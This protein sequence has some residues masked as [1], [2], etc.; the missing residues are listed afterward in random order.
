M[1]DFKWYNINATTLIQNVIQR[2]SEEINASKQSIIRLICDNRL[3]IKQLNRHRNT[4]LK[5]ND[6]YKQM[7]IYFYKYYHRSQHW[8]KVIILLY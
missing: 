1:W 2:Y 3:L 5:I 6:Q 4:K 8:K 7:P